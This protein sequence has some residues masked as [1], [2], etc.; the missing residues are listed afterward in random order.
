VRLKGILAWLL[1]RGVYVTKFPGLDGQLRLVVDWILDVFLPRDITQLRLFHEE[2]VHR[3]HFEKGETIFSHGDTGDKV[4]FIVKGEAAV[5]R[6]GAMLATLRDGEVFGEAA[7]FTKQPRNATL[8]AAT[9]LDAVV[10]SREAFQ[11]LL[12]H[13]P[14]VRQAIHEITKARTVPAEAVPT[15]GFSAKPV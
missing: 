7:L 8:R 11:E 15:R 10:V 13:L 6:N 2:N 12:G 9:T 4:Y 1:W 14:G 3:E 5:E